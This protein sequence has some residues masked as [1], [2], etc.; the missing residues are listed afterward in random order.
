M[1]DRILMAAFCGVVVL[2]MKAGAVGAPGERGLVV[3]PAPAY[4][5][6][7]LPTLGG[8]NSDAAAIN[9]RGQIVGSSN[10]AT[11]HHPSH[12]FLFDH[13]K[14][15]D[16]GTLPGGTLSHAAAINDKGQIVGASDYVPNPY[17]RDDR[18]PYHAFLFE[19]GKMRDLGTLAGLSSQ[20]YGINNLGQVVGSSDSIPYDPNTPDRGHAFLYDHGK[21]HDLGGTGAMALA[22]NDRGQIVGQS[23]FNQPER[24]GTDAVHMTRFDAQEKPQDLGKLGG[25]V[26]QAFAMNAAGTI[27]GSVRSHTSDWR[28]DSTRAVLIRH[29]EVVELGDVPGG[30]GGAVAMALNDHE[31]VV[32]EAS[33][34]DGNSCAFVWRDGQM[35]DLNELVGRQALVANHLK[36]LTLAEGINNS[37]QIV[38][39]AATSDG[40][41]RGFLLTP[42]HSK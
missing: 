23:F 27:A 18:V 6:T 29:G 14:M 17:P 12:A 30:H 8:E 2:G 13:G 32:G 41:T 40:Y 35:L 38:G 5:L 25:Y 37:G 20:A 24:D 16:L 36:T 1:R 10:L 3:A 7:V 26:S 33:D 34:A 19:R 28:H 42:V 11:E 21:M 39:T 4:A 22:I 9:N 15:I 31:Q